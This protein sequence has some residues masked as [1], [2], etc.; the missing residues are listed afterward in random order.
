[1]THAKEQL[2]VS[3]LYL[4]TFLYSV[5]GGIIVPQSSYK[6]GAY[7]YLP[8]KWQRPFRQHVRL[9]RDDGIIHVSEGR[10]N[11]CVNE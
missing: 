2:R 11:E 8:E 6:D 7:T 5:I 1:M 3:S 4:L 9:S 10:M